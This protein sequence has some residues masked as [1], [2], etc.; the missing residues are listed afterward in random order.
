MRPKTW[1][2]LAAAAAM[3][4][5]LAAMAVVVSARTGAGTSAPI[6]DARSGVM[7]RPPTSELAGAPADEEHAGLLPGVPIGD[8][9]TIDEPT[10]L[11]N[12][13][14]FPVYGA[15]LVETE[16][17]TSIEEALS[18][19]KA[20]VRELTADP[21]GA[22][23]RRLAFENKSDEPVLALGGSVFEGGYQDRMIVRDFVLEPGAI[24]E[25]DVHCAERS[26]WSPWRS[27]P[28]RTVDT[29]G[30]F[31]VLAT[32]AGSYLKSTGELTKDQTLMWERVAEVNRAHCQAPPTGTLAA[33]LD[34]T[35][36]KR[37]RDA[38]AARVVRYLDSL[39]MND[40]LVGLG[41]SVDGIVR[42]VRI[43]ATNDLFLHFR[44]ALGRTAAF[45][46][47]AGRTAA[48]HALVD[49]KAEHA[50]GDT[51]RMA[52]EPPPSDETT[53]QGDVVAFV[54]SIREHPQS[55]AETQGGRT[56]MRYLYGKRGYG[57]IAMWRA[58]GQHELPITA[59]FV[60]TPDG[61]T[62]PFKA[63]CAL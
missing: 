48:R 56:T 20:E 23:V 44:H 25:L 49:A 39:P 46:A 12:L 40:H 30:R 17:M 60:A 53:A 35:S 26:R 41:Y 45:E 52:V 36:L 38:V 32:L 58:S 16:R 47:L 51:G 3:A 11:D 1:L 13:A 10:L 19:G 9:V 7:A 50:T 8:G 33:T 42:D 15:R 29:R 28:L 59:S 37:D 24:A 6:Q 22:E 61:T 62:A 43:F 55:T 63:E 14:V 34:D 31:A 54:R 4:A 5:A 57:A 27:S 21:S 2:C 18:Q